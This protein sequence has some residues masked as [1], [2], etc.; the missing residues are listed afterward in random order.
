MEYVNPHAAEKLAD[1]QL[2]KELKEHLIK[3][4][5]WGDEFADQ[6]L[7]EY[8]RYIQML[9]VSQGML[10]P[11]Q[12][13]AQVFQIHQKSNAQ[14]WR[15]L[16]IL[17]IKPLNYDI[18]RKEDEKK[19]LAVYLKT[20]QDYREIFKESPPIEIWEDPI[21]EEMKQNNRMLVIIPVVAILTLAVAFFNGANMILALMAVL[22]F[23]GLAF[24]YVAARND[25]AKKMGEAHEDF[26]F[27]DIN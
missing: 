5:E 15:A 17:L 4:Y 10:A 7:K 12:T 22:S 19:Y 26:D 20:L 13:V 9:A 1:Y 2:P 21:Q 6:V 14:N 16:N 11:S 23:G 3:A 24:L 18:K 8:W 27:S 25:K